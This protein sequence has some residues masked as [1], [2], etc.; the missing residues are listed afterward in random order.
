[1][2]V[3]GSRQLLPCPRQLFPRVVCLENQ[4]IPLILEGLEQRWQGGEVWWPGPDNAA[5]L[6]GEQVFGV[7]FFVGAGLFPVLF[8]V[9]EDEA[10][11]EDSAYTSISCD[12]SGMAKG[13]CDGPVFLDTTGSSGTSPETASIVS[14]NAYHNNR[15][16]TYEHTASWMSRAVPL[17]I[18]NWGRMNTVLF[19]MRLPSSPTFWS[20]AACRASS[21]WST[22]Q[23]AG[24]Q[25]ITRLLLL[26]P[27]LGAALFSFKVQTLNS[28]KRASTAF[29]VLQPRLA[30][31][32]S[33]LFFLS[34]FLLPCFP[35]VIAA[36][37]AFPNALFGKPQARPF[38][39]L[40]TMLTREPGLDEIGLP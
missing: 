19:G 32:V 23:A 3:Q 16:S 28:A 8:D 26:L 17:R 33:R 36:Y 10:L 2:L 24:R 21:G 40:K 1:M 11:L 15:K 14:A 7:E 4:R 12:E 9:L 30:Q 39:S 20:L 35:F 37:C 5:G 13:D 25:P 22:S 34:Y 38:Q 18:G 31:F 29:L 6:D 27:V